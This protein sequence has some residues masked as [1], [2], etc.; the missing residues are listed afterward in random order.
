MKSIDEMTFKNKTF[1][2]T[3]RFSYHTHLHISKCEKTISTEIT[4][5]EQQKNELQLFNENLTEIIYHLYN[6]EGRPILHKG[7]Y[8]LS[9]V[10]D[11]DKY[12][13]VHTIKEIQ[14][15]EQIMWNEWCHSMLK[16][17]H[18]FFGVLQNRF[19][20]FKNA[21]T[22][23]SPLVIE[24]AMKTAAILHNMLLDYDRLNLENTEE[25]WSKLDPDETE[26]YEIDIIEKYNKKKMPEQT[27]I[28][29]LTEDYSMPLVDRDFQP[30][31]VFNEQN[32]LHFAQ[33]LQIHFKHQYRLGIL[34]WP[35]LMG[36]RQR[37]KYPIVTASVENNAVS[38]AALYVRDSD[39]LGRDKNKITYTS[40]VGKGLFSS[41]S[42]K[43]ND[44]I[45]Y[46]S[47]KERGRKALKK[48]IKEGTDGY[49]I[50]FNKKRHLDCYNHCKKGECLASFANSCKKVKCRHD[51]EKIIKS[52]SSICVS[53]KNKIASLKAS[54]S[55][56]PH[57]EIITSY[58]A[59]YK[60]PTPAN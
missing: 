8:L 34:S 4:P 50:H 59:G 47:G 41:V 24:N 1:F 26:H 19:R 51:P 57:T 55:I 46:F 5:D 37:K 40:P 25:F 53:R 56:L 9:D 22:F 58:H 10:E 28:D 21:S 13:C 11:G 7:L 16:D 15:S 23:F 36:R 12:R 29:A 2:F 60:F 3:S 35:K 44:I 52:N 48:S 49:I 20:F 30:I 39:L 45:C 43:K 33:A 27:T 54:C 32:I 17:V 6:S 31:Q 38:R 18:F 42:Y 14:N